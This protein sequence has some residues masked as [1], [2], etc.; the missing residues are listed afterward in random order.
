MRCT[1]RYGASIVIAKPPTM[2]IG[3]TSKSG[4]GSAG[5]TRIAMRATHT[6]AYAQ[7][8]VA[9]T[10]A[11]YLPSSR[12][13]LRVLRYDHSDPAAA[14]ASPIDAPTHGEVI[15]PASSSPSSPSAAATEP[16]HSNI[17]TRVARSRALAVRVDLSA[18]GWNGGYSA[19]G[20][21]PSRRAKS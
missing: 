13:T 14:Q 11:G 17:A 10:I 21:A 12:W 3:R 6:G 9:R 5:T 20:S 8:A 7:T 1:T 19:V 18:G 15:G 2:T 16:A 4:C